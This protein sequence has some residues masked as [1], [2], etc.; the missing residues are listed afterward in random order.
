MGSGFQR[1]CVAGVDGCRSGWFVVFWDLERDQIS[2]DVFQSFGEVISSRLTPS[3]I[4][5][6]VPIGLL[7]AAEAGGRECDRSARKLL[8]S[9][10]ASSVFSP[11]VRPALEATCYADACTLS[12]TSS[13]AKIALSQQCYAIIPK[14][15]EV[16]ELMTPAL[17][18]RVKEVHPELSFQAMA[19]G[20]VTLFP[21]KR[22]GGFRE[23]VDLLHAHGM[24][25]ALTALDEFP[26]SR[27][28]RDDIL[29]ATAAC[30]SA[31]RILLGK[32]DRVAGP[33][34]DAKGIM[35]EIWF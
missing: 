4:A 9:P 30:W 15:R 24:E 22:R 34:R 6:D 35:M 32:A 25:R 19:G 1:E 8:G 5:V 23:R 11:P 20:A 18:D 14:I 21:K 12:R 10:R 17:Q 3:V 31:R 13:P 2:W 26:R 7:E 29:D 28:Q 16:D 27:V 33:H